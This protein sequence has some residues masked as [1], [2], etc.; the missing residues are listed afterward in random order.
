MNQL[1][2]TI[3]KHNET[4]HSKE[5]QILHFNTT[6]IKYTDELSAWGISQRKC[7]ILQKQYEMYTYTKE[8]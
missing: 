8:D 2:D 6:N 4:G 3:Q 1:H 7:D 5:K